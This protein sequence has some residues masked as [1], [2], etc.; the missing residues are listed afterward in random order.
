MERKNK[1]TKVVRKAHEDLI[2]WGKEHVG[3]EPPYTLVG[4]VDEDTAKEHA[5][6]LTKWF[7]S[8]RDSVTE[9]LRAQRDMRAAPD[10]TNRGAAAATNA[11]M[12]V[13]PTAIQHYGTGGKEVML[14]EPGTRLRVENLSH[15]N[16]SVWPP[17]KDPVDRLRQGL[18]YVVEQMQTEHE[19]ENGIG[20][21][22]SSAALKKTR[23]FCK[24]IDRAESG[25]NWARIF[26]KTD[27]F[28]FTK[29]LFYEGPDAHEPGEW[30]REQADVVG[31]EHAHL[32]LYNR[33]S[34]CDDALVGRFC[35]WK[36][37]YEVYWDEDFLN[38]CNEKLANEGLNTFDVNEYLEDVAEIPMI[39]KW[40]GVKDK[41]K[42]ASLQSIASHNI[43][44]PETVKDGAQNCPRQTDP[45]YKDPYSTDRWTK[46]ECGYT[47]D[48]RYSDDAE[49]TDE[50]SDESSWSWKRQHNENEVHDSIWRY[51]NSFV[52]LL[53]H[54]DEDPPFG[55]L[56]L[57]DKYILLS[58]ID[59]DGG[60]WT[61]EGALVMQHPK[62]F[63]SVL[64]TASCC[65]ELG[66]MAM[67]TTGQLA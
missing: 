50:E 49:D 32:P 26:S 59:K 62:K 35:P 66:Q 21:G 57:V 40:R 20:A 46:A 9:A 42:N 5:S 4:D 1:R 39:E 7:T 48:D 56:H 38:S 67:E 2:Q 53:D 27:K 12:V 23:R 34:I 24:E 43:R 64:R 18:G 16:K 63:L 30:P 8:V 29:K 13:G 65:L 58:H 33:T 31:H 37:E 41:Y 22:S 19:R 14:L 44:S 36:A 47:S 55:M 52:S 25:L 17:G 11:N 51:K 60:K 45:T 15:D 3:P 61:K 54:P 6:T 10:V 28:D